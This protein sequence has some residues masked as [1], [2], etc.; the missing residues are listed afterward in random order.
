MYRIMVVPIA[1]EEDVALAR[2]AIQAAHASP[3]AVIALDLRHLDAVLAPQMPAMLDELAR[4]AA[5]NA[6]RLVILA[7]EA[8]VAGAGDRPVLPD[9]RACLLAHAPVSGRSFGMELT[10]PAR[11][12][13]L[14]DVRTHVASAVRDQHGDP[15]GFQVEILLDELC[16]NAVENSPSP[17]SAYDVR[18][19]CEGHELQVDVTNAFDDSVDSEKIMH[20]RLQSF[21]DSGTYLGERG[22]GL[23]LVARI[24]DGLQIRSIDRDRLR[25]TVTKRLGTRRNGEGGAA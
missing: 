5:G 14:A 10:L 19:A 6:Q 18:I 11:T 9:L 8:A 12:E 4:T 23:F 20:R 21:D 16:L 17:R 2:Y 24:A 13:Y 15:D 1:I 7:Q 3:G 22:R 25:V